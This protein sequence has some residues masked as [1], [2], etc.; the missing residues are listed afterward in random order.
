MVSGLLLIPVEGLLG[1][2]AS[3][4]LISMSITLI[5]L[6][7]SL[8]L[9]DLSKRLGIAIIAIVGMSKATSLFTVWG[10]NCADLLA[11]SSLSSQTQDIIIT[12]AVVMLVL[13]STLMLLSERE[14]ASRWEIHLFASENIAAES[15]RSEHRAE[16]CDTISAQ[17]NLSPREDEIFRLLAEGRSNAAIEHE[18]II[19]SGTLKAHIQH[20]YVK[21][22]IHS[23]K[24][25]MEMTDAE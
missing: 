22:N 5:S 2:I 19:A 6:L 15:I 11:S 3:G 7:V 13:A 18:L 4:Y 1:T 20:I 24:E 10:D 8:L 16:R 12:V 17:Y 25:L 23:R 14:L 9:Y 21:L